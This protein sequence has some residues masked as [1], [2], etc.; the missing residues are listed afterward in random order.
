LE[1]E[2]IFEKQPELKL[3]FEKEFGRQQKEVMIKK[4]S[5]EWDN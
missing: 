4:T 2:V 3:V 1:Q 5:E